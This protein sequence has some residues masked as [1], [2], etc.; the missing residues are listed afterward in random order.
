MAALILR[1]RM[2]M[3]SHHPIPMIPIHHP[4]TMSKS[5]M[6][7]LVVITLTMVKEEK[8]ASNVGRFD[9]IKD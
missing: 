4:P 6:G 5:I 7:S 8:L 1:P 9:I 2:M 3:Q